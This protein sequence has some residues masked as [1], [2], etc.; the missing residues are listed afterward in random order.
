[1]AMFYRRPWMPT[2]G[3]GA[4]RQSRIDKDVPF[5]VLPSRYE[6]PRPPKNLLAPTAELA[7]SLFVAPS[8]LPLEL[9]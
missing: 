4:V 5:S 7:I 8:P 3:S 2:R 9:L 1:M 6:E